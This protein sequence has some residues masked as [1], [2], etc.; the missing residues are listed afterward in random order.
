MIK[1]RLITNDDKRYP[2]DFSLDKLMEMLNTS[3]FF[4]LNRQYIIKRSSIDNIELLQKRKYRLTLKPKT[5][6]EIIVSSYRSE[7]FKNW[8]NS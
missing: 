2:V 6:K 8:L 1:K 5:D 3:M 4:R 7:A